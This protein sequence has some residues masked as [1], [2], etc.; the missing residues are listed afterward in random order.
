MTG[1]HRAAL[2]LC[3]AG[4]VIWA[5]PVASPDVAAAGP[6]RQ[7]VWQSPPPVAYGSACS[8]LAGVGVL[9]A[10][11]TFTLRLPTGTFDPRSPAQ[12]TAVPPPPFRDLPEFCR[13]TLTAISPADNFRGVEVWLPTH[14]WNGKLMMVG[15]DRTGTS[16]DLTRMAAALTGGFV[17]ASL[18]QGQAPGSTPP[19]ADQDAITTS[20]SHAAMISLN[21]LLAAFYGWGPRW[22]YW[23][24]CGAGARDGLL[25]A[26][27]YPDDF[28]GILAVALSD[29]VTPAAR[30][31]RAQAAIGL[32]AFRAR[33]GRVLLHDRAAAAAAA[34]LP[35]PE[36]S[37]V[38]LFLVPDEAG[39]PDEDAGRAA[40]LARALEGWVERDSAPD[41][42][43]VPAPGTGPNS[44][45]RLLCP[46]PLVPAYAGGSRD[47]AASFA[48][49]SA[50]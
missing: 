24:G 8:A 12:Q 28:D 49:R 25:T 31:A 11:V 44:R 35:L 18:D 9:R 38:R 17:V 37:A 21:W 50:S 19:S 14:T 27:R 42:I 40:A 39:C 15:R 30:G 32:A 1:A 45:T 10:T 47:D 26:D 4:V 29:T 13:A 2:V 36:L 6:A 23:S 43:V 46:F 48:C 34:M 3:V 33:G 16:L 5:R 7:G 41:R 22:T 20:G